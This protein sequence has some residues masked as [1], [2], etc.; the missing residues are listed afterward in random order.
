[1]VPMRVLL[2]AA[3]MLFAC[4]S[5]P[6]CT[7]AD[8]EVLCEVSEDT[9]TQ[10][11][12]Y[13]CEFTGGIFGGFSELSIEMTSTGDS[14]VHIFTFNYNQYD[15]W[16]MCEDFEANDSFS[17]EFSTGASMEGEIDYDNFYVIFDHPNSCDEEDASTPIVEFSFKVVAK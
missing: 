16:A 11:E 3:M 12:V 10:Y 4:L 13:E 7:G 14:P 9:L 15:S 8:E 2:M 1:M 5:V 6:G 17:E